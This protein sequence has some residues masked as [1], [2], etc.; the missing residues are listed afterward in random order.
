M[1]Q[2][3]EFARRAARLRATMFVALATVFSAC[4]ATDKLTNASDDPID[5]PETPGAPSD[6]SLAGSFRGGIPMGFFA[7]PTSQFGAEYNG[8]M[9]NIWPHALMRELSAIR[10]RGGKVVLMFAGNERHYKVGRSF[11]LTKWKARVARFRHVNFSQYVN[12]GT[13]IAHY[14]ID[15]PNDAHNWG[16]AISPATL[17]EMAKYSK[18][19][20]PNMPTVVRTEASYLARGG[21][22]NHLN[23]AWAQYVTRKGNPAEFIRRNVADAQRAGLALITGLNVLQ[24]GPN[25]SRMSATQIKAAG[26]ALLGSTY[27]CAFI[28]WRFESGYAASSTVRDA[29]R[30]LRSKAQSRPSKTCRG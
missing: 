9:R 22:Y 13:I 4:N 20:W 23:A 18:S 15:E 5:T 26:S 29:M 25:G 28:S 2:I 12:D 8:A 11:S 19:L 30:L 17:E 7:L 14:L 16:R 21:R 6:V 24:G 10:G 27:P 3:V 1:T